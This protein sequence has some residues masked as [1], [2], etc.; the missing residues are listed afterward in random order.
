MELP[1]RPLRRIAGAGTGRPDPH[2]TRGRDIG[3]S[4]RDLDRDGVC[5]LIV[6]N[7]HQ[8]AVFDFSQQG[9]K[10]LKFSLPEAARIVDNQGCDAGLRFVDFNEDG[11]D[12]I[13][14]SNAQ[15]YSA[16]AF[17]Y[18]IRDG[19]TRTDATWQCGGTEARC[20]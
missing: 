11:H 1:G 8:N 12:D 19:W 20:Q 10:R 3:V 9:W 13:V 15:R 4:L 2:A 14:F 6:G 17:T 5:E 7:E 16:H 18:S